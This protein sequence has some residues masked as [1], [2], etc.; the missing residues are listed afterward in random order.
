MCGV[1]K[2][3]CLFIKARCEFRKRNAARPHSFMDLKP[4]GRLAG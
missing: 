4:F 3:E 2:I 1:V